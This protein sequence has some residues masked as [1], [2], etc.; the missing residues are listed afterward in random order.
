[1][2]LNNY[3]INQ[4][5]RAYKNTN[6]KYLL[7]TNKRIKATNVNL[8]GV[9]LNGLEVK[10]LLRNELMDRLKRICGLWTMSC[11]A[12]SFNIFLSQYYGITENMYQSLLKI[13]R[14]MKWD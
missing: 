7:F 5:H 11:Y 6:K 2:D 3:S 1:M 8:Y 14:G 9:V 10:R 12:Y 4:L 13:E